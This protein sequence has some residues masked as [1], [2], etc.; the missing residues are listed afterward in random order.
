MS[1]DKTNQPNKQDAISHAKHRIQRDYE[2]R[3]GNPGMNQEH[4]D[5]AYYAYQAAEEANREYFNTKDLPDWV[6]DSPLVDHDELS[7]HYEDEFYTEG[8]R[9]C[10]A[11]EDRITKA[12]QAAA[13]KKKA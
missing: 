6:T 12:K 3:K 9:R 4:C 10:A 2:S 8:A 7:D 5:V 13:K 1:N 11:F